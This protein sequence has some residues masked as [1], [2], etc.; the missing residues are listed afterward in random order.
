MR[1]FFFFAFSIL[2]GCSSSVVVDGTGGASTS[3]SSGPAC[4]G[5]AVL[6]ADGCG[7]D[8][9]PAQADCIGG[10][11][12]CPPGT[13]DPADCPAGG[14]G[15]APLP[16]EVCYANWECN[17]SAACLQ[18]CPAV[19]CSTCPSEPFSIPGCDCGC[20]ASGQFVCA[21]TESC[22][23]SDIDCGD[24]SFVPC[25]N[26]VCKMPVPDGCWADAECPPAHVCVGASVCPCGADCLQPDKP[27]VCKVLGP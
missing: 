15:G 3:S 24:E 7:S 5:S 27:G 17:P 8:Y 23:A 10:K 21:K 16:C 26:G 9:F 14:C 19:A 2:V 1:T 6:C 25:V 12:V 13:V 11:W 4:S 22:C 18:G 20:D